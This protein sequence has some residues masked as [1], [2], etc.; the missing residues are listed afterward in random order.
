MAALNDSISYH[1]NKEGQQTAE[2]LTFVGERDALLALNAEHGTDIARLQKLLKTAKNALNAVVS[3]TTTIIKDTGSVTVLAGDTIFTDS[4]TFVYPVYQSK[5]KNEWWNVDITASKETA[6]LSGE[7]Y[8]KFQVS[9]QVK[10]NWF[11][12]DVITVV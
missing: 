5:F 1:I 10:K 11:K 12:A 4:T 3:S 8:N 9:H 2:I 7:I 6:F